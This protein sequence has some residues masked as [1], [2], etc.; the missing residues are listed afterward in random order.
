MI[1]PIKAETDYMEQKQEAIEVVMEERS[2]LLRSSGMRRRE[3]SKIKLKH[4]KCRHKDWS[5]QLKA[6]L[7][8][9]EKNVEN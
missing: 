1:F 7:A 9:M 6:R 2:K 8:K 5:R 3:A 4:W